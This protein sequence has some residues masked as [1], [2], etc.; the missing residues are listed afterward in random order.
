MAGDPASRPQRRLGANLRHFVATASWFA[1]PAWPLALWARVVAAPALARAAAL[2][3]GLTVLLM[4][5]AAASLW[6]PPQNENADPAARAARHCSRLQGMLQPAARRRRRRS[7]GSALLTFALFAGAGLARLR[8]HADRAAADRSRATSRAS[9]LASSRSSAVRCPGF[10]ARARR[11]LAVPDVLHRVLADAQR[12]ALGRRHRAALG[13]FRHAV[14]AVGRLPEELP[15]RGARAAL[16]DARPARRCIAERGL[17][18]SQAAALD[19]HGGICRRRSIRAGRAPARWCWCRAARST[20]STPPRSRAAAGSSSPTSA[21]P[22][23]VPSA[24]ASI[25]SEDEH[26]PAH[27]MQSLA[28]AR[29]PCRELARRA[30]ARALRRGRERG[31]PARRRRPRACASTIRASG[32]AL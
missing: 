25:G 9:R 29:A 30:P 27:R 32:W 2:R 21:G 13:H 26:N 31:A 20:S 4:M 15:R 12:C 5:L 28:G 1:W 18:V 8:R 7:T 3:A 10:A 11:R 22:A 16:E 6:G 23:T 14:D 19:Y 17:G 24:T